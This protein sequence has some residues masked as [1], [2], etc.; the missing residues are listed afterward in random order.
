LAQVQAGIQ[1]AQDAGAATGSSKDF[2]NPFPNGWTPTRLD[3]GW[4]GTVKQK[5]VAPFD[6]T[7]MFA[8]PLRG[9][10]NGNHGVVIR[11]N[12]KL[13]SNLHS[14]TLYFYEGL[15]PTVKTGDKVQAG[16]R[17][18]R[19]AR[20]GYNGVVGNIEFGM[21]AEEGRGAQAS[22]LASFYV[23]NKRELVMNFYH[24][25]KNTL[26]VPGQASSTGNAGYP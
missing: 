21:A 22:A 24:W 7:I 3:M 9:W 6:G 5:I 15:V 17:I 23:G 4:D 18:A 25:A 11:A 12:L 2:V 8:G 26:H 13:P 20:N 16:Q 14:N 19:P 1:A 10:G